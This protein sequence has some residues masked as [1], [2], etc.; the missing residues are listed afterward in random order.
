VIP[1]AI[2]GF[3]KPA[4]IDEALA[5][6]R[7]GAK[8]IAGGMSLVPML[9]LRLA[10]PDALVDLG[11]IRDLAGIREDAGALVIGATSTHRDVAA[12][13]VVAR[14]APVISQAAAGV[15]SPAVRN[16]GTIGGSLAHADPHADLPAAMLALGASVTVRSHAGSRTISAADLVTDYLTTSLADDELI[17]DVRIPADSAKSAYAKFHRR[18]I[19]WSIIGAAAVIR[20]GQTRVALTGVGNH[21]VRATAFEQ[22]VNGGAALDQAAQH[23]GDGLNPLDDLDGSS[24]YKRHLAGVLARRA[25]EAARNA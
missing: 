22:A 1:T 14:L 8:P 12:S 2:S 18:A 11:G 20:G 24:D 17:I 9:R 25:V 6:L 4:T 3:T 16:R 19:D 21:P 7:D 23:A 10:A 5:A 13:S 15:G